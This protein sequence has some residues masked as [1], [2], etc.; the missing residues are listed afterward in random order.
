MGSAPPTSD[1]GDT[2]DTG[3]AADGDSFR[4]TLGRDVHDRL[5][6][7]RA[8]FT[9]RNGGPLPGTRIGRSLGHVARSTTAFSRSVGLS[10]A[11]RWQLQRATQDDLG[12][13]GTVRPPMEHWPFIETEEVPDDEAWTADGG[14]PS[15][16]RSAARP[17]PMRR[18]AQR[19]RRAPSAG[20]AASAEATSGRAANPVTPG[21]PSI[22]A[23]SAPAPAR[24]DKLDLLRRALAQRPELLGG[25]A[26]PASAPDATDT[27]RPR[28]DA[29][30]ADAPRADV[31]RA[32][33]PRTGVPLDAGPAPRRG[34]PIVARRSGRTW[35][36]PDTAPGRIAAESAPEATGAIDLGRIDGSTSLRRAGGGNAVPP[37]AFAPSADAPRRPTARAARP[38]KLDLLREALV[39]AGML[40]G[41]DPAASAGADASAV[42]A[43]RPTTTPVR[44]DGRGTSP[45]RRAAAGMTVTERVAEPSRDDAPV[46]RSAAESSAR[47]TG[48]PPPASAPLDLR[49]GVRPDASAAPS[50]EG[51]R[52]DAAALD[53]WWGPTAPPSQEPPA[54]EPRAHEAQG[55]GVPVLEL[56][57]RPEARIDARA[58]AG[59]G[60]AA[61]DRSRV[62]AVDA[63]S[64]PRGS[65]TR[66]AEPRPLPRALGTVAGARA[67]APTVRRSVADPTGEAATRATAATRG[68]PGAATAT[69]GPMAGVTTAARPNALAPMP[70]PMV[71]VGPAPD[72]DGPPAAV[73]VTRPPMIGASPIAVAPYVEQVTAGAWQDRAADVLVRTA[74]RRSRHEAPDVHRGASEISPAPRRERRSLRRAADGRGLVRPSPSPLPVPPPS[75]PAAPGAASDVTAPTSAAIP[76]ASPSQ[77]AAATG[78]PGAIAD[79]PPY[80]TLLAPTD[81]AVTTTHDL[82]VRA[83]ATPRPDEPTALPGEIAPSR[84]IAE[85]RRITESRETTESRDVAPPTNGAH[86]GP[87]TAA[88]LGRPSVAAASP[89]SPDERVDAARA[90]DVSAAPGNVARHSPVVRRSRRHGHVL[91]RSAA[92]VDSA[93]TIEAAT[94]ADSAGAASTP[95]ATLQRA[96]TPAAFGLD[97]I[98][99]AALAAFAAGPRPSPTAPPLT[100][101]GDGTVT[102][103]RIAAVQRRV[104][105]RSPD[106]AAPPAPAPAPRPVPIERDDRPVGLPRALRSVPL[107]ADVP[108][109]A[110]AASTSAPSTP[111]PNAPASSAPEPRTAAPN[112]PAARVAREPA[113]V[114]QPAARVPA[115]PPARL[116]DRF[117]HELSRHRVERPVALP[118]AFRPMAEMIAPER[119]PLVS[120]GEGSRRALAAVGKVAATT[121]DVIHLAVAPTPAT[122][123]PRSPLAEVIAHELTHVA[124]ASPAPRFFA[125]DRDSAEE[126]RAHA[127]GELMRRSPVAPKI[128]SAPPDPT[129]GVS[130]S[131]TSGSTVVQRSPST[132]SAGPGRSD[133]ISA[134]ELAARLGGGDTGTVR[135][136]PAA[137][138]RPSPVAASADRPATPTSFTAS[139]SSSGDVVR[140]EYTDDS[141]SSTSGGGATHG[142]V[143]AANFE[144]HLREHFDLI[145]DLLEQRIITQ[146]ERRGGRYR[147]DF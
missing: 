29:P 134:A 81:V 7:H 23:A 140:R 51:S 15:V 139:R 5:R 69:T 98:S 131:Q 107:H 21:M 54:R 67:A 2:G 45:L 20:A 61:P 53:R 40:P 30:R 94:T 52:I 77:V 87:T 130:M 76:A 47:P 138:E 4:S 124:H 73:E 93:I 106:V 141:D 44:A 19:I 122:V 132:P 11:A 117:L 62:P 43:P 97:A 13:A 91:R 34:L 102:P 78:H 46:R 50:A 72:G 9:G 123:S 104:E 66:A 8:T 64:G 129:R 70:M 84:Q 60:T 135:R 58:D 32:D 145:V 114:A 80:R 33:V 118:A 100:G 121:G 115:P 18:R 74:E 125:D 116:E 112:V 75:T 95:G 128:A 48:S 90:R 14:T 88:T 68:T 49:A 6:L 35:A 12:W 147:G 109:P 57:V 113:A 92:P 105:E 146:L 101:A 137:L 136:A 31:P 1:A 39:N 99:G 103:E 27:G 108:A 37:A 79:P 26:A 119:R 144:A 16:G 133:T 143:T 120:A 3:A 41:S 63:V 25:A 38:S 42:A 24:V 56:P 71:L 96:A 65:G 110:T 89:V 17:T 28:A 86:P 55:P 22:G 83:A 126:R 111:A 59:D 36:G 127:I 142:T 85:P 82:P 10:Q